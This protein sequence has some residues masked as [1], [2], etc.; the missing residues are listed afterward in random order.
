MGRR[1]PL[2]ATVGH[3]VMDLVILATIL[4]AQTHAY[5]LN[6]NNLSTLSA[7]TQQ[8][9][10]SRSHKND[11]HCKLFSSQQV[12]SLPTSN[13]LRQIASPSAKKDNGIRP[14]IQS[15]RSTTD[16]NQIYD[17]KIGDEDYEGDDYESDYENTESDGL[18]DY[19]SDVDTP[20]PFEYNSRGEL[21]VPAIQRLQRR[22]STKSIR[23]IFRETLVNTS[24]IIL[25]LIVHSDSTST[26]DDG[27]TVYSSNDAISKVMEA[28]KKGITTFLLIPRVD[29]KL[30]SPSANEGYNHEGMLPLLISNIKDKIPNVNIIADANV[31]HYTHEGY[32]GLVTIPG[33]IDND[34]TVQQVARQVSFALE[35]KNFILSFSLI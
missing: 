19:A 23:K 17:D 4:L 35:F 6:H 11:K 13:T 32:D 28:K 27:I 7:V 2:R 20:E 10:Y 21:Y 1:Q 24:N 8:L 29:D 5:I 15:L 16:D 34:A 33:K 18:S 25:P 22:R 9:Q 30:K 12:C 31:S 26:D 3:G 14:R